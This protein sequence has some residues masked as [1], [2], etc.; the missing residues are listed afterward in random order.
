MT[1]Y[2][3]VRFIIKEP[4]AKRGSIWK[5]GEVEEVKG[6]KERGKTKLKSGRNSDE[7][8]NCKREKHVNEWMTD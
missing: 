7:E 3:I 4:V 2:S 6:D 1:M 5:R 8:E